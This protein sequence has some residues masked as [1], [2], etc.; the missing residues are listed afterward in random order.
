M[1][2]AV[3]EAKRHTTWA[4]PDERYEN[5]VLALV[6]SALAPGNDFLARFA[7]FAS[8][9]AR[10]GVRNS[11]VQLAL[12]LTAPGVPDVYQGAELWDFSLVDPDNRRAVDFAERSRMLD[13]IDEELTRERVRAL[14]RRL[15]AWQDGSIKLAVTRILL[16][17]RAREA[18]LFMH[19]NY[20]PCAATGPRAQEIVAFVREHERRLVVTAVQRFPVRGE[21]SRD[22]AGTR[23][24]VGRRVRAVDVLTG[25]SIE[26][27]SL[28]P[29]ELFATLPIAVLAARGADAETV[30]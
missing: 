26:G 4:A 18:P 27:E 21:R 22:W 3:R 23:L 2:K 28:D 17:L 8:R 15:A 16:A 24:P 19:G 9:V 7:P 12:K 25:R 14:E 29:A 10:L 1:I 30:R 11:L 20:A 6:D 5:A 13:R